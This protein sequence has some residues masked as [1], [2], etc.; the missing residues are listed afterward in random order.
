MENQSFLVPNLSLDL[1]R[2]LVAAAAR[3][4][5][6]WP[7]ATISQAPWLFYTNSAPS[8]G[9]G[10]LYACQNSVGF[11]A[12]SCFCVW[13][14]RGIVAVQNLAHASCQNQ[15]WPPAELRLSAACDRLPRSPR[16]APRP[17][18]GIAGMLGW[19]E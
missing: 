7:H 18:P 9:G 8:D 3:A 10:M 5:F 1:H 4:M 13:F 2:R 11:S 6:A 15:S 17:R 14:C 16:A 19:L 12:A